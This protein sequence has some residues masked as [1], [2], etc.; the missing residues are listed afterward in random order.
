MKH[1]LINDQSKYYDTEGRPAILD[2]EEEFTVTEMIGFC[3][4]SIFKYK[5]RSGSKSLI[6][7]RIAKVVRQHFAQTPDLHTMFITEHKNDV[8]FGDLKKIETY[9][10][11]LKVLQ[12]LKR[13]GHGDKI[14]K[15][16][17]EWEGIEWDE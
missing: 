7:G 2:A 14:V 11:Y 3:K 15:E 6:T 13:K 10:N 8:R 16:A 4:M 9:E 5:K 1:V 12:E 17:L